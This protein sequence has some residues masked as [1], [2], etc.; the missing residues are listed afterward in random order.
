MLKRK[1]FLKFEKKHI[2]KEQLR[3]LYTTKKLSIKQTSSIL[4]MGVSTIHRKLHRYGIKVR[5]IGKKRVDITFSKLHFLKEKGFSVNKIAQHFNCNQYTIRKRMDKFGIKYRTKR[6]AITGYPK[7]NFSGNLLEAA[8]LI[9]FGLG[10]LSIKRQGE[11]IYVRVST[12]RMEQ[13][14]LFKKLFSKY[15][16]VQTSKKDKQGAVRLYCYLD[17]S[18]NFLLVKKDRVPKWIHNNTNNLSAFTAGYIDAEGS[19][20]INQGRARFKVDSYDKNILHHIHRWLVGEKINS[21]LRLIAEKG[22]ERP[23]GYSFNNDLWRLNVNEAHS[24]LKFINIIKPF[25]DH[26][27]RIKD[28]NTALDNIKIRKQKGTI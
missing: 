3:R 4:G 13:I 24:L 17:D 14:D 7:K 10:D 8:Y 15:T 28:V 12:T 9:G 2:P 21:K 19:F 20:G 25:M 11:L 6:E 5:P 18:F 27:K 23:E 22:E 1:G 16:Y 26:R